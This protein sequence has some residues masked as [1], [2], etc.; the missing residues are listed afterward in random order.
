MYLSIA[1]A[2][3]LMLR[4]D[5]LQ[6]K[7]D[8]MTFQLPGLPQID[9]NEALASMHEVMVYESPR[10]AHTLANALSSA[11]THC[12]SRHIY[13]A[14]GNRL[15]CFNLSHLI[16]HV[17]RPYASFD[18]CIVVQ[19]PSSFQVT[20]ITFNQMLSHGDQ[21]LNLSDS[22]FKWHSNHDDNHD[23]QSKPEPIYPDEIISMS[24]EQTI[25]LSVLILLIMYSFYS[26]HC[27][28]IFVFILGLVIPSSSQCVLKV[29]SI[30]HASSP[31]GMYFNF[32]KEIANHLLDNT[33]WNEYVFTVYVNWDYTQPISV[34]LWNEMNGGSIGTAHG[35]KNPKSSITPNDWSV[36]DIIEFAD[37]PCT[38]TTSKVYADIY[39]YPCTFTVASNDHSEKSDGMYFNFWADDVAEILNTWD[40]WYD[41]YYLYNSRT[42]AVVEVMI[43]NTMEYGSIGSA[44]GRR[45]PRSVATT[46]DWE[47]G[48]ELAF[49]NYPCGCKP[50]TTTP[51]SSP[52]A[53]PTIAPTSR[54]SALPTIAPTSRPSAAPTIAPTSHPSTIAPT[55]YPSV[56][57]IIAPSVIPTQPPSTNPA[58]APTINPSGPTLSAP[59]PS[60][61][62]SK[63]MSATPTEAPSESPIESPTASSTKAPSSSTKAPSRSPRP[64]NPTINPLPYTS[65]LTVRSTV[66]PS[67]YQTESENPSM[68]PTNNPSIYPSVIPSFGLLDYDEKEAELDA[69]RVMYQWTAGGFVVFCLLICMTGYIDS[70]WIRT[71]DYFEYLSIGTMMLATLDMVSDCFFAVEVSIREMRIIFYGSVLFIGLPSL[72]ALFQ[73]H[74]H[75]TKYW[76]DGGRVT[77]WIQKYIAVLLLV[78]IVTG[79]AFAAVSLMNSG[80]YHMDV[81]YMGLTKYQ[82]QTFNI[83]KMYSIVFL[84]D[85]PQLCLQSYYLWISED[86]HNPIAISSIILSMVSIIV[87]AMHLSIEKQINYHQKYVIVKLHV[88]GECVVQ[89][90]SNCKTLYHDLK[91]ELSTYLGINEDSIEIMKPTN[92]DGGVKVRIILT[93]NGKNDRQNDKRVD[94]LDDDDADETYEARDEE[95]LERFMPMPKKLTQELSDYVKQINYNRVRELFEHPAAA[96]VFEANWKLD[97][98]TEATLDVSVEMVME[99]SKQHKKKMLYH[100]ERTA[101]NCIQVIIRWLR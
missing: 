15:D 41:T 44:H 48:D 98:D 36:D 67:R 32:D 40:F 65:V 14:N 88:T 60:A 57:P 78:S 43:W 96:K 12:T 81:F 27:L 10:A 90:R 28:L 73:L 45:E 38:C 93:K 46:S 3:I 89:K 79:N 61:G 5:Q 33:W 19:Y 29:L 92:I 70:R 11:Y 71:N 52:S 47:I 23:S 49:V 72:V 53:R 80:L 34:M 99:E 85:V 13:D 87:S 56:V 94:T 95:D 82:L 18:S 76:L 74:F 35:R 1:C 59:S 97:I 42:H 7:D 9:S 68:Y 51:T 101:V 4:N 58:L 31:G 83:Q 2:I 77:P 84:E 75:T 6:D 86:V 24:E 64:T 21:A 62:P 8:S 100:T 55:A 20:S 69:L 50:V 63:A 39:D 30:D 37:K 54:P 91:R 25:A 17:T 16:Y 66:N 22:P 26:V